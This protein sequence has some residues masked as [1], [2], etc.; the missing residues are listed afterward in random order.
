MSVLPRV[1]PPIAPSHDNHLPVPDY[2]MPAPPAQDYEPETPSIPI[3]H[4]I[5][6][7]RRHCWKILVFVLKALLRDAIT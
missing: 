5:W 3:S 2:Y 7:L 6:I 4:Y 1:F